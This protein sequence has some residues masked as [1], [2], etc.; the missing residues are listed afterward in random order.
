MA[1]QEVLAPASAAAV[2]DAIRSFAAA[3]GWTVERN[4]LVG[5]LRTL[6]LSRAGLDYVHIYNPTTAELRILGSIDYASGTAPEATT[7]R[8]KFSA[9][10]MSGIGPYTK[11]FMF[12]GATPSPYLHVVIE[13]ATA[14]VYRHISFG[15]I[16]KWE[17]FTGGTYT[18]A[19]NW[20]SSGSSQA[21]GYNGNN[22]A[23]FGRDN[24]SSGSTQGDS[25]RC[26]FAADSR[27][28]AWFSITN[29]QGELSAAA[30][31]ISNQTDLTAIVNN[32]D[33]NV[34]SNRSILHPTDLKINRVGNY[35][36][37]IGR[38][39]NVRFC[40][41][42]KY[43]PADEITIGSDIWKIFPM[44]RK[45]TPNL[46]TAFPVYDAHSNY[47]AYAYKKEA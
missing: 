15:M 22:H 32:C 13:L 43:T 29:N 46:N 5:S 6:T 19:S 17:A 2:I 45:F 8:S 27:T 12:A 20:N 41:I 39:P 40:S 9:V 24:T 33:E 4:N 35:W 1:Y 28:D 44:C 7:R 30:G 11:M 10:N 37:R 36:S 38:F 18:A 31:I 16:E 25:V 47:Y 3:N 21:P 34:F 14:G 23:L 26:D 42:F